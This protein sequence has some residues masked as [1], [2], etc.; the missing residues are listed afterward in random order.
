MKIAQIIAP[1]KTLGPGERI[2]LWVQGCHR[3]CKGCISP[4][5]QGEHGTEIPVPVLIKMIKDIQAR[6]RIDRIT[7]S[8]GD[9]FEQPEELNELLCGIRDVFSDILVYTGFEL[10]EIETGLCGTSGKKAL[11]YVDVLIDGPYVE[12]LNNSSALKGSDNQVIHFLNKTKEK[13]YTDYIEQGRT[14]ENIV[15]NGTLYTIGIMNRGVE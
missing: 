10:R 1:I 11:D 14:I 9:P 3:N 13:E 15:I 5:Y 2:G 6:E 4:E 7:I 12:I 8:G